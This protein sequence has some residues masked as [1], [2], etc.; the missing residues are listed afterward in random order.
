[1]SLIRYRPLHS[2]LSRWPAF[3]DEDIGMFA[4]QSSNN[5]DVYE[6]DDEVVVKA[7]VAGIPAD[8][9]DITFEEG[10]LWIKAEKQAEEKDESK[11]HYVKSSWNYSYKVSVPG[12][13]DHS[14]D[15]KLTLSDGIVSITFRKSEASKPKKLRI[16]GGT[17]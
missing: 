14:A 15:P 5:L 3:D 12:L 8:D 4:N 11:Q 1:M 16:G 7:N 13:I 2:M 17:K 10:I 6:T 9:I